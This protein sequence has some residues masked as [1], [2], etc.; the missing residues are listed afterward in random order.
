MTLSA[1]PQAAAKDEPCVTPTVPTVQIREIGIH[2]KL[3]VQ[4]PGPN[5]ISD[6]DHA[7]SPD[8]RFCP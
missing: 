2:D 7:R 3:G 1:G 6:H 5:L 4:E 8:E